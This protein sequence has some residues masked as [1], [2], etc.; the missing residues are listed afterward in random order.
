MRKDRK[1]KAM[2]T[3]RMY[4]SRNNRKWVYVGKSPIWDQVENIIE[5]L[6]KKGYIT[7]IEREF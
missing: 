7:K 3:Y 2:K 1:E 6:E 5:E 4:K